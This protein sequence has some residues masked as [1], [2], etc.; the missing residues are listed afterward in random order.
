M[1]TYWCLFGLVSLILARE[2]GGFVVV[3]IGIVWR[4]ISFPCSIAAVV[5]GFRRPSPS[6]FSATPH[7]RSAITADILQFNGSS[8]VSHH[9]ELLL[10]PPVA[11]TQKSALLYL[12]SLPSPSSGDSLAAH[13]RT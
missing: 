5:V 9:P 6:F 1:A 7:H 13:G 8:A 10:Q 2:G 4:K 12:P 3:R 11:K